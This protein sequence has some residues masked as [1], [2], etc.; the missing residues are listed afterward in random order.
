VIEAAIQALKNGKTR[1]TP[2]NGIP[3][4]REA[5]ARKYSHEYGLSYDPDNEIIVT[6]GATEAVAIALMTLVNPGDDVLL[7]DPGF[8]SNRI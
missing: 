3:E 8:V 7:P 6:V 2:S 5:L 4:L 1:Y